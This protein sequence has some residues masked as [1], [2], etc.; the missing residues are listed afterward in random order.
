ML[1]WRGMKQLPGLNKAERYG[2]T[3]A[4]SQQQQHMSEHDADQI[5]SHAA[6]ILQQCY[7]SVFRRLNDY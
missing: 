3:T 1:N 7:G 4:F 2:S 6:H 5:M